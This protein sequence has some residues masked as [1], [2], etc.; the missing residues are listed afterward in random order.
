MNTG[1]TISE[2]NWP[3]DFTGTTLKLY[4]HRTEKYVDIGLLANRNQYYC[5]EI[6]SLNSSP[7]DLITVYGVKG[8]P[9]REA[10]LWKGTAGS[11]NKTEKMEDILL[12]DSLENCKELA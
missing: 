7:C 4:H 6:S 9:C 12:N 10:V 8:N 3:K 11:E 2:A 1:L 5:A